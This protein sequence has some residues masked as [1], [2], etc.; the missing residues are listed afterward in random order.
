MKIPID[1]EGFLLPVSDRLI[2]VLDHELAK[3]LPDLEC[4][5]DLSSITYNFRDPDYS[6]NLGGYHPVEIGLSRTGLLFDFDYIT[7]FS[8]VGSGWD[9][10]LAKEV[11]FDF[12]A[13]IC[14]IRYMK[15]MPLKEAK[16]FFEMFQSNL[17]S[18]LEMGVFNIEVMADFG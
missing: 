9:T 17:L 11:D 5:T 6:S 7:D 14:E 8:Y 13:D 15:P 3:H 1:T 16:E 12:Q 10:E 4:A 2:E 18:Y